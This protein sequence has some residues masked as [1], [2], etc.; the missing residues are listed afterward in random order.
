MFVLSKIFGING[1]WA[2]AI[3]AE[4]ATYVTMRLKTS[5]ETSTKEML[6]A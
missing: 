6:A 3:V 4:G 2:A 1:I 5:I